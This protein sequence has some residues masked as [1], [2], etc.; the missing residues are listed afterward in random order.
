MLEQNS[1]QSNAQNLKRDPF[2]FD[3][4]EGKSAEPAP[5]WPRPEPNYFYD[6]DL[7]SKSAPKYKIT[8]K[9]TGKYSFW[10]NFNS[11]ISIGFTLLLVTSYI[12]AAIIPLT[13]IYPDVL[14]ALASLKFLFVPNLYFAIR[15]YNHKEPL[16]KIATWI[17]CIGILF[18]PIAIAFHLRN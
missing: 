9:D 13:Q 7:N 5:V 8:D 2:G 11:Y 6:K 3:K 4:N 10:N 1:P 15:S 18:I 16:F 17:L 14:Y 12:V